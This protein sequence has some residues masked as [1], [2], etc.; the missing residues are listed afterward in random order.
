MI[1]SASIA[2]GVLGLQA[3]GPDPAPLLLKEEQMYL[4]HSVTHGET[5]LVMTAE[6]ED[7]LGTVEVRGPNGAKVLQMGVAAHRG[8]SLQGFDIET[9]ETSTENLVKTYPEGVYELRAL[10]LSGAPALGRAVLSHDLLAPTVIT[11]PAEGAV[12]V[13]THG[14]TLT[15][16]PDSQAAGYQVGLEQGEND[17]LSASL[18][19]GA[20]SFEVP[21]GYLA[22]GTATQFEIQAIGE[23]GNRTL[24]EIHFTTL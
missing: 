8:Q 1:A 17:G 13:P 15:W 9:A 12:G 24:V 11:Y 5:V 3:A 6:S 10:A 14:L 21:D 23:N 19:S 20:S 2:L 16:V 18:P 7:P 22:S 4:E